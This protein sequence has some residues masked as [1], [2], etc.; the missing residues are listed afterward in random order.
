MPTR[1]SSRAWQDLLAG[2][3]PPARRQF[4]VLSGQDAE[5]LTEVTTPVGR[6]DEPGTRPGA[7][8]VESAFPL[9]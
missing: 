8:R 6:D 1:T 9:G 7:V 4:G 5:R 3:V 2:P